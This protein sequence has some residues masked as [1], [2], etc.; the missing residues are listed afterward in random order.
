[1]C[2]Y[3][4][5]LEA[6]FNGEFVEGQNQEYKIQQ[7]DEEVI[8]LL[9]H[10]LYTQ[11]LDTMNLEEIRKKEDPN[12]AGQD[13]VHQDKALIQLWIL[14]ERLLIPRLQ[15]SAMDE[16]MRVHYHTNIIPTCHFRYVYENT[17]VDSA[18]RRV[19]VDTFVGHFSTPD[20]YDEYPKQFSQEMLL[21]IVK[22]LTEGTTFPHR[23]KFMPDRNMDAYHVAED[24]EI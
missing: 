12:G 1:M 8:R 2:H 16:P 15:N 21:D 11:K 9:V 4:P 3:S 17:A 22:K 20:L 10:W 13:Q 23:T 5:V 18:L 7:V 14:G 19:F 6:A 24:S